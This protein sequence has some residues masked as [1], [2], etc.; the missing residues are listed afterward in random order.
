M[1]WA[2]PKHRFSQAFKDS[3]ISIFAL[4]VTVFA[5]FLIGVAVG[6]DGRTSWGDWIGAFVAGIALSI[7]AYAILIQAKQGESASWNIALSRLGEIYDQALNDPALAAL[8]TESADYQCKQLESYNIDNPKLKIWVG[9][10]L[11]CYEQI[12]VATK[13]LS[14]ESAR[15]WRLYLRNQL[16]KPF[17]RK[18][19][20]EDAKNALDFHN[21]FWRFVRGRRTRSGDYVDY[22]IHPQYFN[23]QELP[24]VVS[25]IDAINLTYSEFKITDFTNW[26]A[27]YS[28]EVIQA[29]MYSVDFS[30][31]DDF[32]QRNEGKY[33]YSVFA[34]KDFVGGFKISPISE[35]IGT[36]GLFLLPAYRGRGLAKQVIQFIEQEA[37]NLGFLTLRADVFAD[38]APSLRALRRSGYRDFVWLEKNLL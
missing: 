22:V 20:V 1:N 11:L 27:A 30:D 15:V 8:I 19:F 23:T 2:K 17:I 37:A 3:A 24:E 10:L 21:D 25:R 36:F 4:L 34:V 6:E 32:L 31:L 14:A 38:N 29:Q 28:D 35:T 9:S 12:Y 16:N 18:A 33:L 26:A 13:S 7:S 5:T